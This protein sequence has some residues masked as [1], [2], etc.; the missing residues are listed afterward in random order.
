MCFFDVFFEWDFFRSRFPVIL[1]KICRFN[2]RPRNLQKAKSHQ[3][4]A[5]MVDRRRLW[6][7]KSHNSCYVSVPTRLAAWAFRWKMKKIDI[8]GKGS[9]RVLRSCFA[10]RFFLECMCVSRRR[11]W[12]YPIYVS[13]NSIQFPLAWRFRPTES[14]VASG[15]LNSTGVWG[16]RRRTKVP[17]HTSSQL[18]SLA[19][20]SLRNDLSWNVS[21]CSTRDQGSICVSRRG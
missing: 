3:V 16:R 4:K 14:P 6:D 20:F 19:P 17:V 5:A 21:T 8:N 1:S 10:S 11:F 9:L 13:A 2:S 12:V 18:D 7:E 15:F